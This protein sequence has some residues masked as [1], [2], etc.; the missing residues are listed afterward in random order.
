MLSTTYNF[1]EFA[2]GASI[3]FIPLNLAE[4]A[5]T[6]SIKHGVDEQAE[7][8]KLDDKIFIIELTSTSNCINETF[9]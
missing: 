7:N 8:N 2:Y 4:E 6:L 1:D 5:T 3:V 9:V